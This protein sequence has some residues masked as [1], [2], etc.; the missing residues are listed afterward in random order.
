[1]NAETNDSRRGLTALKRLLWILTVS[2]L[3]SL[4]L[5]IGYALYTRAAYKEKI[6][7]GVRVSGISLGGL[8]KA[9]AEALLRERLTFPFAAA[10]AFRYNGDVWH[11]IPDDLG[12]QIQFTATVENAF[13]YGRGKDELLNMQRRVKAL[14]VGKNFEPVLLFDERVA[15]NFITGI[16]QYI[17]IAMEQPSITL[18]GSSVEITPGK[19]GRILDR[20]LTLKMLEMLAESMQTTDLDLPVVALETTAENLAEKKA[21]LEQILGASFKLYVSEEGGY[22][23]VDEIPGDLLAGWINFTPMIDKSHISIEMTVKRDPFYNRLV[24][25]SVD[26]YQ[27]PQNAK[28]IFN[29][30]TRQLEPFADAVV[31]KELDIETSLKNIQ[32]AIQEGRSDAELTL[33]I[34]EPEIQATA[35]AAELGITELAFSQFTYFYG[36]SPERVQ[37]I[38]AGSAPFHG[39]LVKP[40]EVFSMAEN[41]GDINLENGFAEGAV[42]VGDET[43]QGVGGG[44]CQVSTTLFRTALNYGLPITERHPHAYRVFY[45][46]RLAN[47][48]IDPNLS[49]LDASVFF[50]VLDLKFK[51]DTPYWILM[52][53]YVNPSASS[54]QWKFYSTKVNRYV[55]LETT[56][57]TN[58]TEPEEP[59]YRESP[60]LA[61]GVIEQ[62]DWPVKGADVDVVRTVYENGY[63]HLQDRFVTNYRP[64]RAIYEYGPGTENIPTP[65]PE[66]TS[67]PT[68]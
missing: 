46:E 35:T 40:G 38:T 50:P 41:I 59:L 11:G 12:M 10:F 4:L 57:P 2:L 61:T 16:A 25:L 52:E 33:K 5:F 58:L 48:N 45:Y 7:P 20:A 26:L 27:K 68:P 31:G 34:S 15:F 22:R 67:T 32:T 39:M 64:Q 30:D 21:Q 9:E 54:I 8:T 60:K 66:G 56:G 36:S 17:D 65:K 13:N 19:S 24:A 44:I 62:L 29:D 51:N 37:N 55:E 1:M 42:I 28:F 47:G 6:F 43:V 23:V 63:V 14:M 3:I 49:G 18:Q 53:V